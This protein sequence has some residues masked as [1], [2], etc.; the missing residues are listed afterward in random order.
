MGSKGKQE[1]Q[2]QWIQIAVVGPAGKK[3]MKM[4]VINDQLKAECAD[5]RVLA[6]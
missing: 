5:Q 2:G 4:R 6:A 3:T 1:L